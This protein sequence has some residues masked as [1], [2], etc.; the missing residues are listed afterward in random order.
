M[1]P[2]IRDIETGTQGDGSGTDEEYSYPSV[3]QDGDGKINVA[4]TY[5]RLTIK[6]VRF[7]EEWIKNGNTDGVFRGDHDK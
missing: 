3:L 5:R 4:Y 6:V 2:W 7:D 1:W